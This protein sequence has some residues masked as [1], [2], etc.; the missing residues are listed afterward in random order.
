MDEKTD[1]MSLVLK[2]R[3]GAKTMTSTYTGRSKSFLALP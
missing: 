2:R 1:V 3:A